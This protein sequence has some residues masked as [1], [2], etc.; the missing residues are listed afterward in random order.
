MKRRDK[1]KE[2][3]KTAG[4]NI[5]WKMPRPSI[6]KVDRHKAVSGETVSRHGRELVLTKLG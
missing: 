3:G 1:I 6:I 5:V 2:E 4:V